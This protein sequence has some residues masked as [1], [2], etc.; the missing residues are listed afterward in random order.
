MVE[1]VD[2]LPTLLEAL[3]VPLAHHRLE[4]RSLLPLLEGTATEWRNSVYSELDYSYRL[5]RLLRNKS[6][7]N[8]RAWS[9]RNE[10]WRYV[11]WQDEPEQLFDLEADPNE[12]VDL[13]RDPGHAEVRSRFRSELL[14]WFSRLKRRTTVSYEA[15]ERGTNAY[16]KA[17]VFYGQW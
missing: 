10:R 4:G 3:G 7:A 11:F 6:P 1:S 13:G 12:F 15:I 2:I 8:A 9:I 5:A 14:D 16:K 17:G